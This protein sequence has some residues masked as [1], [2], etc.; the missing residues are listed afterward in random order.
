MR[1]FPK[2][3]ASFLLVAT[4]SGCGSTA[5]V[6]SPVRSPRA[7]AGGNSSESLD[8]VLSD[9]GIVL[10][11]GGQDPQYFVFTGFDF[12]ELYFTFTADRKDVVRFLA[13]YHP[14]GSLPL[15][16]DSGVPGCSSLCDNVG[17]NHERVPWRLSESD[18]KIMTL[19][20]AYSI[21][22]GT[23][24]IAIDPKDSGLAVYLTVS[25]RT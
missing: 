12:R 6:G 11:S 8:A 7:Q 10:P 18:K 19:N 16:L 4:I 24:T 5:K 22:G 21:T 13:G 9:F 20:P 3:F 14:A 2:A 15:S 1:S 17:E 25:Q 23:L